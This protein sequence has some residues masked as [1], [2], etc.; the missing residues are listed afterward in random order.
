MRM[1]MA[2]SSGEA[3]SFR[4]LSHTA[5][6]RDGYRPA[7]ETYLCLG[8]SPF[9]VSDSRSRNAI[10]EHKNLEHTRF[11]AWHVLLLVQRMFEHVE[12]WVLKWVEAKPVATLSHWNTPF[13]SPDPG[14]KCHF[15][16]FSFS[17]ACRCTC[18]VQL[19]SFYLPQNTY[20]SDGLF[21]I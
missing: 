1:T 6:Q 3:W 13:S 18:V 16:L 17:H 10:L 5:G 14:L 4:Y 15:L 21:G 9:Q 7:L 19:K 20:L 2:L 11:Q 12:I 8:E